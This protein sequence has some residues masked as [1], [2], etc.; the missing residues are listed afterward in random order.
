MLILKRNHITLDCDSRINLNYATLDCIDSNTKITSDC[1]FE[2]SPNSCV[3]HANLIF[4]RFLKT[5]M[6]VLV[7]H[8]KI[9]ETALLKILQLFMKLYT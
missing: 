2:R 1:M 4:Y 7:M 5:L 9:K 8:M 3:F 6:K